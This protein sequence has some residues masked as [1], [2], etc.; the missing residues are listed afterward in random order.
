MSEVRDVVESD[1]GRIGA[2]GLVVTGGAAA[3]AGAAAWRLESYLAAGVAVHLLASL[4]VWLGVLL[5]E[6][7]RRR[8]FDGLACLGRELPLLGL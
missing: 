6:D 4:P 5:T 7:R 8:A 2:A 1:G 3:L